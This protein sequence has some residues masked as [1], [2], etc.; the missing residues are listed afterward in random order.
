MAK[1]RR[2]KKSAGK[3][4]PVARR[5]PARRKKAAKKKAARR[6]QPKSEAHPV[7]PAPSSIPMDTPVADA[8]YTSAPLFPG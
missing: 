2:R 3:K 8:S 7:E 1:K 6:T 4:K 5:K